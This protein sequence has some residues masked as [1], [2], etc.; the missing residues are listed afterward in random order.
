MRMSDV[1]NFLCGRLWWNDCIPVGTEYVQCLWL[2]GTFKISQLLSVYLI[3]CCTASS[4]ITW[5]DAWHSVLLNQRRRQPFLFKSHLSKI[6]SAIF[7]AV[8]LGTKA[9]YIFKAMFILGP[10][11]K[12]S[13]LSYTHQT[14]CT[15]VVLHSCNQDRNFNHNVCFLLGYAWDNTAFSFL[16][17]PKGS[18]ENQMLNIKRLF[19]CEIFQ[20]C[21]II[22]C[23]FFSGPAS[24]P[25]G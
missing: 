17:I 11:I 22:M 6:I 9:C 5:N 3:V 12:T 25:F 15:S 18:L 13:V 19:P 16:I 14:A 24:W 21:K 23:V 4:D 10:R 2:L 7:S 8:S 1:Q 20:Q